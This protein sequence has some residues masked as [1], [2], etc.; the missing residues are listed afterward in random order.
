MKSASGRAKT[1]KPK[2]GRPL[3]PVDPKVVEGMATVGAT[4]AEIGDFV[5]CDG[6]TIG[7]RFTD[8]L[9]KAR[10][11]MRLR[12]R[13]AQFKTAV[14]GNPTMLIWLGKQMLDQK[15]QHELTGADGQPLIP[16]GIKVTLV[17][18]TAE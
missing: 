16:R 10:S 1:R 2:T 9:T 8:I 17:R 4:N 14:G 13:Q 3:H 11:G 7:R 12:L 18:P 6:D 5:G 15:D